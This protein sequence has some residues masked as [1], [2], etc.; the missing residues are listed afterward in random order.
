MPFSGAGVFN[1]LYNWV[2]DRNAAI[3]IRADRMDAEM[4]GFAT[5][6]S[7]CITKDGQTTVTQDIPFNNKRLTGVADATAGTDALNRQAADARFALAR[8]QPQGRLTL[9]SGVPVSTSDQTAKTTLYYTPYTGNGIL[10]YVSSVWTQRT[11]AEISLSLSGYTTGKPFDIFA[12]DN[13]G[14]VALESLVWTND[15]TRATALTRQDGVP[16]KSGDATRLYLGTIYTSATGQCEDSKGK[17]YVWNAY[18][19]VPRKLYRAEPNA[20]WSYSTDTFRQANAS[21]ANQFDMVIG[22][23]E[24]AVEAEIIVTMS[25]SVG[26]AA[27]RVAF[28]VDS[29]TTATAEQLTRYFSTANAGAFYTIGASYR[30]NPGAGKHSLVWLERAS[31]IGATTW[32]GVSSGILQSG[33]IGVVRA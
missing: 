26:G 24:D 17:R 28:G 5:G 3:K 1:R 4:D 32:Y 25:N 14:T 9:E 27:V 10:L 19:R 12:Y 6:L 15:T 30:D 33:M 31:A 16:V 22:L 8:A 7:N 18:N 20:S 21:A 23:A 29:T 13:A 11:F 2:S